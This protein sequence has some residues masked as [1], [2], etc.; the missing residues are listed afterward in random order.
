M[1]KKVEY[2]YHAM[3]RRGSGKLPINKKMIEEVLYFLDEY[4]DEELCELFE[5]LER[6]N[7]DDR[8]INC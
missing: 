4:Y 8:N 1:N 6:R 7:K 2:I 3:I 5:E